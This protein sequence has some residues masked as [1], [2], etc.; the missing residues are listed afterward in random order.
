MAGLIELR[1]LLSGRTRLVRVSVLDSRQRRLY[2]AIPDCY[3]SAKSTSASVCSDSSGAKLQFPGSFIFRIRGT[4]KPWRRTAQAAS[5][6]GR[7]RAQ[8]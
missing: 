4:G 2:G 6:H 1:N 3:W 7:S 8:L 5:K